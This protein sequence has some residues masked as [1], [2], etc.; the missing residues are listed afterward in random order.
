MAGSKCGIVTLSQGTSKPSKWQSKTELWR[1][2]RLTVLVHPVGLKIHCVRD[3]LRLDQL[4]QLREKCSSRRQGSPRR[5]HHGHAS[6]SLSS[7]NAIIQPGRTRLQRRRNHHRQSRQA[8]GRAVPPPFR[9]SPRKATS[10]TST[11]LLETMFWASLSWQ[12]IGRKTF[13]SSISRMREKRTSSAKS[14]MR[15]HRNQRDSYAKG[16][17][18]GFQHSGLAR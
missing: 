6:Q 18:T 10:P 8:H 3:R 1:H 2:S 16:I 9:Y 14:P 15:W 12:T 13:R 11:G 4:D 17:V 5:R 7:Q